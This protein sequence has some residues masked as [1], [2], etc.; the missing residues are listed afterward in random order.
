MTNGASGALG[1]IV[2]VAYSFYLYTCYKRTNKLFHWH[3]STSCCAKILRLIPFFIGCGAV[4]L[5]NL[6]GSIVFVS[7]FPR[8]QVIITSQIGA[9]SSIHKQG[10]RYNTRVG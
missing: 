1:I 10:I 8:L 2:C 3:S 9:R 4:S 5:D 7:V 6:T